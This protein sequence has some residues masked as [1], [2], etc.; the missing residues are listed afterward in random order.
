M[1]KKISTLP[2]IVLLIAALLLPALGARAAEGDTKD[3]RF[4]KFD[5]AG[6]KHDRAVSDLDGDGLMDLAIVYSRSNVP[7]TY[8]LRA[9]L[10]DKAKG[11]TGACEDLKLA[12]DVRAF[13]VGEVDGKPGAELVVLTDK[14]VKVASFSDGK[15]GAFVGAGPE[16]S[17]LSG[18]EDDAPRLLRFLWDLDGDG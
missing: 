10:Q 4:F 14:G 6:A 5:F 12:K 16:K 17:I 1:R 7:D 3:Y 11:F 9:C 8:W 2:G 15:F 13:D 18:T